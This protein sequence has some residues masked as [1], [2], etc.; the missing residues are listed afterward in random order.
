VSK[1]QFNKVAKSVMS[2]RPIKRGEYFAVEQ[3][4]AVETLSLLLSGMYKHNWLTQ[5]TE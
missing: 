5:I 1:Q 3:E 4:T 2:I